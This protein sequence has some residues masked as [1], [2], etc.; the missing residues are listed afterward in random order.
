[1][2][3]HLIPMTFTEIVSCITGNGSLALFNNNISA[4]HLVE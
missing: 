2:V 4:E 3:C 1:M